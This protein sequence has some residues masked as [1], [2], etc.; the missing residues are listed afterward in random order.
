METPRPYRFRLPFEHGAWWTFFSCL[1]AGGLQALAWKADLMVLAC[2]AL[3]MACFFLASHWVMDLALAALEKGRRPALAWGSLR[4]WS[5]LASGALLLGVA[6]WRAP[7]GLGAQLALG[8]ALAALAIGAVLGLR[9]KLHERSLG[10]LMPS[11]M[12]L[13]L[14]AWLLGG[15]AFASLGLKALLFWSAWGCFFAAGVLY[16]QTWLRGGTLPLWRVYAGSLPYL[17]E[18]LVLSFFFSWPGA[19]AMALFSLRLL[20]R[21]HQRLG[22]WR[23]LRA[24]LSG[25]PA[26]QRLPTDGLEIRKL[27]WEQ[28]A[29]SLVVAAFLSLHFAP[30]P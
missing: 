13:T 10:L 20:W 29:W 16:I 30:R 4:G 1:A 12:L 15:L 11:A 26:P 25:G 2:L 3:G 7:Q 6:L 5:L 21:L 27:G 23:E 9:L 17:A 14:P 24:E 22:A 28:V 8:L 19:L 18:S